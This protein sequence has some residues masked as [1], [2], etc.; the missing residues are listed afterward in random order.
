MNFKIG[1]YK[2]QVSRYLNIRLKMKYFF[3]I[4]FKTLRP[5]S[6]LKC[7]NN[8]DSTLPFNFFSNNQIVFQSFFLLFF[9]P[10]NVCEALS[11]LF[12]RILNVRAH[13]SADGS[14]E[15]YKSMDRKKITEKTYALNIDIVYFE[16]PVVMCYNASIFLIWKPPL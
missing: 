16:K 13:N 7:N 3:A 6:W 14:C 4:Y 11:R 12:T 8:M 5:L 1:F 10:T 2:P 9:S 15:L